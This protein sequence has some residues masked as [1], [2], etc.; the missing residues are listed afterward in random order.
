MPV[1]RRWP[2]ATSN[3][4]GESRSAA[5]PRDD[6]LAELGQRLRGREVAEP[7]VDTLDALVGEAPVVLKQL[8]AGADHR[9]RVP[10]SP[11]GQRRD[12]VA[13]GAARDE[14]GHLL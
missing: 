1:S 3:G 9:A 7:G 13:V 10:E 2:S 12:G 8:G 14:R 5:E 4:P 11:C 6:L